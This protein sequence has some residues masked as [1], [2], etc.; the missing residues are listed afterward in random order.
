MSPVT[1]S[2]SRGRTQSLND[3]LRALYPSAIW[4]S[5]RR[6]PPAF[7]MLCAYIF[8]EYVRPQ[9]A[10]PSLAIL[11]WGVAT[12]ALSLA[13]FLGGQGRRDRPW[14]GA[15]TALTLF[16]IAIICSTVTSTYPDWSVKGLEFY[17][18]WLLIYLLVGGLVVTPRRMVIFTGLYLLWS[19]KMAQHGARTLVGRGFA[20]ADWGATG[21]Q[22]WFHNS[23]EF[24]IQMCIFLPM[25]YHF[26]LGLRHNLR[27]WLFWAGMVGTTGAAGLSIIASSSRG[28]QLGAAIVVLFL[29]LQSRHR[30]RA[31]VAALGVVAMLWIALPEEQKARFDEMGEDQTSQ[32]RL[33]YWKDGWEILN[34]YPVFGIGYDAWEP[35][36]QTR[37]NPRGELPH[38]IFVEAGAE[39]GYS[40]LSCFVVLIGVT[41]ALN[42]RTRRYAS[43]LDEWG[44]Y[45]RHAAFGLDAAL[46]GYLVSGMFVTVLFYPYFWVNLAFTAA[47]YE[48]AR[49]LARKRRQR[50]SGARLVDH[51]YT[52]HVNDTFEIATV[53]R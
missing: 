16:S 18:N 36:Y 26:F 31:S 38:N 53:T 27:P 50:G 43:R 52:N 28:G 34:D 40:G 7:W 44:G 22:G 4:A 19:L 10:Y 23:G 51:H 13:F 49:S 6:E 32:T 8:V 21:G 5:L 2:R 24:A 33:A 20:F 41:F 3:R 37:Y 42:W 11:P 12:L 29:I 25:A 47:T 46:V 9:S 1:T 45:L 48:T 35:F 15:D 17:V 30:V 39:L 14:T